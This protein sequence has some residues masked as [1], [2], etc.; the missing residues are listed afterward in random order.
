MNPAEQQDVRIRRAHIIREVVE[1]ILLVAIVFTAI[2][3]SID[4]R[5][6]Q[7]TSMLPNYHSGD[8]FIANKLAYVFGSP[9]RGDV[10]V[11]YYP[12][13]PSHVLIKRIIGIPGDTL[14]ITPTTVSINGHVLDEPYISSPGNPTVGQ[15]TLGANQ[16]FVMGDNRPISCDSRS[17]GPLPRNDII[18]KVT[19]V[20]WP[21]NTI[22]GVNTYSS[23]FSG[24][25]TRAPPAQTTSTF[26]AAVGCTF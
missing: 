23:V 10:I 7:E 9:Q 16:Y 6:V 22:R 8:K 17:W 21:L 18:G 5:E 14:V 20:Y 24:I 3:L 1:I 12:A 26:G 11:F 15:I 13:D 4:T 19:L 2:K 25:P